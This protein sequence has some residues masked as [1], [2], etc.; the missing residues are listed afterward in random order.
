MQN[1]NTLTPQ[2]LTDISADNF[3]QAYRYF[4]E[5][6]DFIALTRQFE[7]GFVQTGTDNQLSFK[8]KKSEN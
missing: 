6:G 3:I 7:Q 2:K 5:Q 8:V 4:V 1:N